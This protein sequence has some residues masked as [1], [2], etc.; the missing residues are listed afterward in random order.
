MN[1]EKREY[2]LEDKVVTK[3]EN[4]EKKLMETQEQL[5]KHENYIRVHLF[6]E[7]TTRTVGN[8]KRAR[9]VDTFEGDEFYDRTLEKNEGINLDALRNEHFENSTEDY[10]KLKN[11]LEELLKKQQELNK[12]LMENCT[13]MAGNVE[14]MDEY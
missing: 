14:E 13:E 5:E 1:R 4:L 6:G 11:R 3:K 8:E 12:R 2:G 10:Y 9:E 7:E